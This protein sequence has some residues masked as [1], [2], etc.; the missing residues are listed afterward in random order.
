MTLEEQILHLEI[1]RDACLDEIEQEVQVGM[2][3]LR[4]RMSPTRFFKRHMISSMATAGI[5]GILVPWLAAQ[6][7]GKAWP[8]RRPAEKADAAGADR[9]E[10]SVAPARKSDATSSP[11]GSAG[12]L[13]SAVVRT[14]AVEVAS[15]LDI[16]ALISRLVKKPKSPDNTEAKNG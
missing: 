7:V 3:H 11:R 16:P 10:S 1:Q 14:A 12:R 6:T 4:A 15:R 9:C 8:W 5:T 13:L 2:R